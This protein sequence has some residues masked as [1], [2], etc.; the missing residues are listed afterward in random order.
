MSSKT[1]RSFNPKDGT[2]ANVPI[3]PIHP[4]KFCGKRL[5]GTNVFIGNWF[6]DRLKVC[7]FLNRKISRIGFFFII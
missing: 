5:F 4:E 6:E 7:F 2:Y 1:D 3:I